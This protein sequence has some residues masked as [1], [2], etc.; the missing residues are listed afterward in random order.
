V[1]LTS[2]IIR[3]L[4]EMEIC[5]HSPSFGNILP[6][7][8]FA[9]PTSIGASRCYWQIFNRWPL[10]NAVP[11]FAPP[12]PLGNLAH[13]SRQQTWRI[14]LANK[15][16]TILPLLGEGRG[17]GGRNFFPQGHL[18]PLPSPTTSGCTGISARG[19][20]GG[21]GLVYPADVAGS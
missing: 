17:E 5:T 19:L 11:R 15:C 1:I 9:V 6:T 12:P 20:R 21:A 4:A 3:A 14:H 8:S 2:K 18:F 13:P 7:V 10:G 16:R